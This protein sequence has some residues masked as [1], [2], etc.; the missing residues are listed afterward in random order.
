MT[1]NECK[2]VLDNIELIL[3][4]IPELSRDDLD[5]VW[6]EGFTIVDVSDI[7]DHALDEIKEQLT[8]INF[9]E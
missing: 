9:Y 2:E 7:I 6:S 3:S 8:R 5:V 1:S 4:E